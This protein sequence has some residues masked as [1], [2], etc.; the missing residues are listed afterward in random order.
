[1][2]VTR[3]DARFA[4]TFA[5]ALLVG[6]F[7]GSRTSGAEG[8]NPQMLVE[9]VVEAAG[10]P[11]ALKAKKDVEYTYLY[12]KGATGKLDVSVE[13]YVFDGEKSWARYAVHENVEPDA[14]GRVIQGYDG[15]ATG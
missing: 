6:L 15:K 14:Q 13:R 5:L 12:R 11:G 9:K 8:P 2:Q 3:N 4:A 7:A 10:G 1:M